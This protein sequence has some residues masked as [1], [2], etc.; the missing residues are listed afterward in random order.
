MPSFFY[1]DIVESFTEYLFVFL[2]F[3]WAFVVK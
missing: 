3:L 1:V 2:G